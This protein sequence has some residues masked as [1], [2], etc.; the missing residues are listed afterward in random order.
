M[1]IYWNGESK[2]IIGEKIKLLRKRKKLTQKGLAEKLQLEG[3]EFSDLTILRIEQGTRFV[4]DYEVV[5][6]ADFFGI[7]TDELLKN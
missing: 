4:P 7:T 3:H 6:L 2:N 1:K 5:I